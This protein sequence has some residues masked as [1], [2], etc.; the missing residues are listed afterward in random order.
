MEQAMARHGIRR[1]V[2]AALLVQRANE[3]ILD[4][5]DKHVHSDVRVVS[6]YNNTLHIACKH[7]A[8]VRAAQIIA[9]PLKSELEIH[10][11]SVTIKQVYCRVDPSAV[12]PP[13]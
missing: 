11:P 6:F 2:T 7:S 13:Y 5:L 1:Q 8:A 4:A 9:D 3:L 12:N 10:F